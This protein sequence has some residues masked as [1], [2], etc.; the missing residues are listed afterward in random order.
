VTYELVI[1][2]CDGVLIDSE[3]IANRVLA[4]QLASIGIFLPLE[5]VM[6]KFVGRTRA[7]CLGLAAELLGRDVPKGF[8]EDW[9]AALFDAFERELKA[10]EGVADL[11]QALALPF[12]AAS[13]SSPDRM[14]VSLRAADLL[15]FFEGRMYS[16]TDVARPKPAPDLF[17]HA[18]R[19]L[20]A[21]PARCAVIEDTPT[22]VRA[23]VAA[24]MTVFGYGGG[25]HSNPA[26]LEREGARV[27]DHMSD[28]PALLLSRARCGSMGDG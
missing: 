23:G 22:G 19:S 9:D 13:N 4:G 17:L 2:D 1:F 24:G 6:R 11:L 27:F 16:A 8:A 26:D 21:A 15:P 7:G 20:S 3:P 5:E 10:I 25:A 12:C 18:A 14:R 28:L